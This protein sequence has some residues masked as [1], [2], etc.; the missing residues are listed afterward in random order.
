[1]K[2][3]W[4]ITRKEV[5]GYFGSPMA[6]IFVGVFLAATLFTFFWV[7]AFFARGVAEVRPLFQWMPVLLIFLV[8]ALTMR[9]WSEEQRSGTQEVL[10]TLPVPSVRLVLGKFLAVM[11][12]VGTAL[13]LTLF[14]PVSVSLMGPLDWGPVV[15]GYL[16]ALLLAAA[17]AAIGLFISSRTDN[18]IVA[19]I[20]TVLLGG[21]FYLV[22]SP[23]VAGSV[24]G[25]VGEVLRAIGSGSRFESIQRGVVD[26][27]DLAYYLALA[28]FFLTLNVVSLEAKRWG[29][30]RPAR[31]VR[32]EVLGTAALVLLN[33]VLLNVWLSP[34]VVL[35]LD[36]TAG[37]DY[38]LSPATYNL[39]AGL[40]EPLLIRGYF[41]EETHPL[42]APLVPRI[43]DILEEYRIAS[44]GKVQV[45]I[46][47]PTKDPN[48]EAEAN[49]VYSIF[50]EPFRVTGRYET[51]IINSYFHILVRYGDQNTV[52][53]YRDLIEV[54]TNPDGSVDVRLRNPEYDLTRSIKKVVYGFQNVEAMLAA[55]DRPAE[56][57]LYATPQT[58]PE[59][60]AAVP[61]TIAKVAGEM[62][63][64][65]RGH[66]TFR[67][68]DPDAPDSPITRQQLYDRYGIRPIA[69]SLFTS[70]SFYL[71]M[72]LAMGDQVQV[73]YPGL[74]M[75][76]S[77]IRT[78]IEAA[79]KRIAPG[80]MKVVGLWTPSLPP[81]QNIFGQLQQPLSSWDQARQA[82][83]E[84][85][86]VRTVDLRSGRV[87]EDVN[88]LVL[89]AP[90]NLTE[91]E[92][93]AVDQYLMRGGSVIVAAGNYGLTADPI[94]GWP[95]LQPLENGL[96]TLLAAYGVRV[97]PGLVLDLQ[98]DPWVV[99]IE[100][101]V[102]GQTVS[103]LAAIDYPY[104][105]DI[106]RSGMAGN[107]PIIADL[108]AVT[109]HWT[110]PISV[111]PAL[112]RQTTVLL[113]SSPNSWVTTEVPTDLEMYPAEGFPPPKE[114]R[115]YPLAVAVQGVF[116]SAYKGQSPPKLPG[117]EEPP[118]VI[119]S[120]PDTA[121]LVVIGSAEFLDDLV[122]DV[123]SRLIGDTYLNNLKLLQNAVS[124]ATE[125]VD[126]LSIRTRGSF[127]R[128][129]RPM[130]EGERSAWEVGNYAVALLALVALGVVWNIRRR[131]EK[132]LPL[133]VRAEVKR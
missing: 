106:R 29:R 110:S 46:V 93:F 125:D 18:Q 118:A 24:G 119:E 81:T 36:L 55:L 22:G 71:H 109:L 105:V 97:E 122:F 37:R 17:Y 19:L 16:A 63:E 129:L 115:S 104:F 133:P 41:S 79:I 99:R 123:S 98:N 113:R 121:R 87:P 10:L 33:L 102:A 95:M 69:T 72:V 28:G 90:Q 94:T 44:G 88:A 54:T 47:D 25:T 103:Q 132:P 27:R 3:I 38:S 56:L 111:T 58:L 91:T 34:L 83:Q 43:R 35:R 60:L 131:R 73:I 101:A 61:D 82:L 117:G 77:D 21:I 11:A 40:R 15:G 45:E 6:L 4:A 86:E 124:W 85:Y 96:G 84:E 107:S 67:T 74:Q 32:Q 89:I 70:E 53:T 48:L 42:L 12:L 9:Q 23:A 51:G 100:R 126:L 13:A 62:V 30:G 65:S 31:A 116:Q 114:L 52:L 26:I 75:G 80:F 76:E 5:A 57:T 49:Q 112:E 120:S 127:V 66:L 92:R 130:E 39:L 14:L 8:A 20:L 50:P 108:Q 7:G 128:V 2:Q 64:K 68:V 59:S 78:A 1:M